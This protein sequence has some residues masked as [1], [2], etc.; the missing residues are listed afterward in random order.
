MQCAR[1]RSGC[2]PPWLPGCQCCSS[3][4]QTGRQYCAVDSITTSWTSHDEPFGK[5]RNWSGYAQLSPLQLV[6]PFHGN[7]RHHHRQ[8]LLV[9]I[10]RRNSIWHILLAGAES[11]PKLLM[12]THV[13]IARSPGGR[14]TP[15]Y[16]PQCA[17]SGSDS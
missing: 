16:S 15:N 6:V 17:R 1:H 2:F 13:A 14:A 4:A 8:H 9:N 5:R 3:A 7:I 10:N 12:Q 11:V